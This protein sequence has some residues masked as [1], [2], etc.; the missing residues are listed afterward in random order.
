MI[1]V[2]SPGF[3]TTIQDL[4]RMGSQEYGVPYSGVMDKYAVSMANALI[5]NEAQAAVIEMTM[6]GAT[7]QFQ[8]DTLICLSG[9]DMKSESLLP[10]RGKASQTTI[11]T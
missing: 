5:G 10:I 7:F 6:V 2:L 1:K 3:Y 8:N 11:I 4:G 9:A